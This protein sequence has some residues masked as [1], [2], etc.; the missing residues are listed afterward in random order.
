MIKTVAYATKFDDVVMYLGVMLCTID[1]KCKFSAYIQIETTPPFHIKAAW[2]T[3]SFPSFSHS[4]VVAPGSKKVIGPHTFQNWG[5]HHSGY[6]WAYFTAAAAIGMRKEEVD[7]F[8]SRLDKV[9]VKFK[10]KYSPSVELKSECPPDVSETDT[11]VEANGLEEHTGM[12][13][14]SQPTQPTQLEGVSK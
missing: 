5:A 12:E 3:F 10:K 13:S 14:G 6:P 11:G 8:A 9:F 7:T 1:V 2:D 4:R